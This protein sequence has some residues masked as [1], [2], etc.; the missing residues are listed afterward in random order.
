M[1]VQIGQKKAIMQLQKKI[2]S[3]VKQAQVNLKGTEC[4]KVELCN[5]GE[6]SKVA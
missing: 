2:Q 5:Q 6:G 3:G 4:Y 1:A